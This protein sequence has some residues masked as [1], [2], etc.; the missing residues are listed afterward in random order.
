MNSLARKVQLILFYGISA[1]FL[2]SSSGLL[3][4]PR[5]AHC[6]CTLTLGDDRYH[7]SAG[8]ASVFQFELL[9]FQSG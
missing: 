7:V 6:Y 2:S 9:K 1:G 8:T 3:Q 5:N 4:F